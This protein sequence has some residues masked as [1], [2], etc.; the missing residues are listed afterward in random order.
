MLA[1]NP[2]AMIHA[3]IMNK[4]SPSPFMKYL[5]GPVAAGVFKAASWV[6]PDG[7][8]RTV[9][10]SAADVQRAAFD[11]EDPELGRYPKDLYLDGARIV[12]PAAESFDKAKQKELWDFS[13]ELAGL[14]GQSIV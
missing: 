9:E 12:K 1:V 3:N 7:I 5:V 14:A 11:V 6:H 2:G 10:K 8:M 13:I 4:M